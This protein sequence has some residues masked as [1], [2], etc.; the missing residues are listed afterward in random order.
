M[1]VL[2]CLCT[3][4]DA[5]T[6]RSLAERLVD[7]RLCACVNLLPGAVSIYRWQ[8]Q[9]EEAQETVLMIKTTTQAWPRLQQR[10]QALH[11]HDV[12]ELIAVPVE[13]GLPAYL[14]WVRSESGPA[15]QASE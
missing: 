13:H 6:A 11:P 1:S 8:G 2:L 10:V 3:C 12:P 7:E 14:Q 4:P 15:L 9:R 5:A